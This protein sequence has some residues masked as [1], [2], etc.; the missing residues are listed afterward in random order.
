MRQDH[1]AQQ[2]RTDEWINELA[3]QLDARSTAN[4]YRLDRQD[5][6]HALVGDHSREKDV[7]RQDS[8]GVLPSLCWIRMI[9]VK[10]NCGTRDLKVLHQ[11]RSLFTGNLKRIG[12]LD[13]GASRGSAIHNTLEP[14]IARGDDLERDGHFDF[15]FCFESRVEG[16]DI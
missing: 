15:V 11:D 5:F 8:G 13:E 4:G 14:I 16:I 12:K 6:R 2:S 10:R 1:G 9:C 7:A 3:D